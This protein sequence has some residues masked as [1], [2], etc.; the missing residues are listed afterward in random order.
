[1]SI[2]DL[3]RTAIESAREGRESILSYRFN[4]PGGDVD[5]YANVVVEGE[6]IVCEDA[7]VYPAS[8]PP[9]IKKSTIAKILLSELRALHRIGQKL[10]Y[11][12]MDVRGKRVLGSSSARPGKIVNI[13]LRRGGK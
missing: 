7:C 9:G 1:M 5:F 10:G 6:I 4:T 12:S 11:P 8:D 3:L 13:K 2:E